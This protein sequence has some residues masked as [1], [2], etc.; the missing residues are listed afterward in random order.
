MSKYEIGTKLNWVILASRF[1][2]KKSERKTQHI[3]HTNNIIDKP[4]KYDVRIYLF[5]Y[6]KAK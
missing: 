2:E 6:F 5:K 4:H 3:H 1:E